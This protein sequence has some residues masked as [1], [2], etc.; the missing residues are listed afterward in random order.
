VRKKHESRYEEACCIGEV[1]VDSF[2][3]PW[4]PSKCFCN[5]RAKSF[6]RRQ[7]CRQSNYNLA[8]SAHSLFPFPSL[9]S[10]LTR[11]LHFTW[12]KLLLSST[13]VCKG[14]QSVSSSFLFFVNNKKTFH[15]NEILFLYLFI[16]GLLNF[17]Y[18]WTRAH[19]MPN[20]LCIKKDVH[21]SQTHFKEER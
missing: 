3:P 16:L 6:L 9:F 7:M 12:K 21:V 5:R 1:R 2:E 20:Y 11:F 15:Y 17:Y 19:R 14:V 4:W 10:F 8:R 18:L 13:M